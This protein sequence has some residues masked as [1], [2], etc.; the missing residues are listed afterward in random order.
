MVYIAALSTPVIQVY[1][2]SQAQLELLLIDQTAIKILTKYLDY[3]DVFL[4]DLAMELHKNTGINKYVIKLVEG[5]QLFYKPIYSLKL[6]KLENL[7][8]YI[9]TYLNTGFI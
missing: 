4:F 8:T 5:K 6:I 9:E 3:P 7:K 2:T 1:L